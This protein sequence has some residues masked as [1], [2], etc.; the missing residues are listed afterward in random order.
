MNKTH[1]RR[2]GKGR[3][4]L[5][6]RRQGALDRLLKTNDPDKRQQEE[7]KVLQK[8]LGGYED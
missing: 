7:I 6:R 4:A 3:H 1:R 2:V 8:R 5:K